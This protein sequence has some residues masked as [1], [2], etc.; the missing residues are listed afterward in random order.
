MKKKRL[1]SIFLS[2]CTL[3]GMVPS[4]VFAINDEGGSTTGSSSVAA[5]EEDSGDK[6]L[7]SLMNMITSSTP[8]GF[9]DDSTTPYGTKQDEIFTLLR[10]DE[11]FTFI[12]NGG[13]VTESSLMD[14]LAKTEFTKTKNGSNY[15]GSYISGSKSDTNGN[16][17]ALRFAQGVAFDPYGCGRRNYVAIVGYWHDAEQN[18]NGQDTGSVYLLI[19]NADANVLVCTHTLRAADVRLRAVMGQLTVV[20]SPNFFS[21]TAGDY[22]NDGKDTLVVYTGCVTSTSDTGLYEVTYQ[23]MSCTQKTIGTGTSSNNDSLLNSYYMSNTDSIMSS[24]ELRNQLTV[25]LATGDFN[26]DGA[27]DLLVLSGLNYPTSCYDACIPQL[28]IRVNSIGTYGR[29]SVWT[30]SI[31]GYSDSKYRSITSGS[32]SVGDVNEDGKS[33]VV[34]AGFYTEVGKLKDHSVKDHHIGYVILDKSTK[35]GTVSVKKLSNSNISGISQGD[36]LRENEYAIQQFAVECVAMRGVGQKEFVFLNGYLY[37]YNKSSGNLELLGSSYGSMM[38]NSNFNILHKAV[39]SYS[40]SDI[41]EVFIY[42]TSVG[43]VMATD[44]GEEAILL[45]VGYKTHTNANDKSKDQEGSYY[46]SKMIIYMNG[47]PD[48]AVCFDYF[49]EYDSTQRDGLTKSPTCVSG[50]GADGISCLLIAVDS[51]SDSVVAKYSQKAYTYTDPSP[52]A[53]LQA[54]PYFEEFDPGNSSTT[55]SYSESYS[56]TSGTTKEYTYDIG[57]TS[58]IETSAIKMSFDA[59]CSYELSEEFTKTMDTTYTTTF[60]ANDKNQVIIRQTVVYY[61]LYD[62]MTGVDD[63]GNP[64]WAEDSYVIAVPQ[65]PV[66][67]SLTVEQ[68][69]ALAGAYNAKVAELKASGDPDVDDH[70]LPTI[71][72]TQIE[73]YYLDNEGNPYNYAP[74]STS[75]KNGYDMYLEDGSS[76]WMRLS[77]AGGTLSQACTVSM[78]TEQSTTTSEG[79]YVNTSVMVGAEAFGIGA[80]GGISAGYSRMSGHTYSTA[81]M[82]EKETAGAVQNLTASDPTTY[83]FMWKLI[84][85]KDNSFLSGIP[86]IGYAVSKVSALLQPVSDLE[87]DY[88]YVD[89]T[90]TLTWTTP[91]FANGRGTID[92]FKVYQ[93]GEEIGWVD[94]AGAGQENS[95]VLDASTMD[96]K[97]TTFTVVSASLSNEKLNSMHSN[98][99]LCLLVLSATETLEKINQAIAALEE[100]I[101][102]LDVVTPEELAAAI[103]ELTEAYQAA[104]ALLK[105]YADALAEDLTALEAAM[106]SADQ[107]LQEAIDQVQENLDK[108]IEALNAAIA[109]GD[110][111]N[112][113]ALS[114][115]VAELTAAYQA[116]DALL[117]ADID[118][119]SDRLDALQTSMNEAYQALQEAIELVQVNVDT[120]VEE[121]RKAIAAGNQASADAL[122]QAVAELT[123]AYQAADALLQAENDSL[124]A[125]LDELKEAL[126][127]LTSQ[128]EAQNTKFEGEIENLTS[129]D[130]GQGETL[131]STRTIAMVGLCI[132]AVSLLGNLGLLGYELS[133]KKKIPVA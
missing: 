125:D 104:D 44:D 84:G 131:G 12:S 11:M 117:K 85:W 37:E 78:T 2:L 108:A 128:V 17:F 14:D 30:Y 38:T 75:Y 58:E 116:A 18:K 47:G 43:N 68:Y 69:N 52:V 72:Q 96:I 5:A 77:H 132:S 53:F 133:R 9:D 34:V 54:A 15:I 121:L 6:L 10:K 107:A 109:A 3:I 114:K 56:Y 22:N 62:V 130:Q 124:R 67:T 76:V 16:L 73:K 102:A 70:S 60:E 29:A 48:G 111:E 36:S 127:A 57:F 90:I 87:A 31:G 115:A 82:T 94:N 4:M 39:T 119:L 20:D 92:G 26:N 89:E 28:R 24:T 46:F 105:E 21:I 40:G 51:G 95:Y 7:E 66:I 126:S 98:E 112:A 100:K 86:C 61:Y 74:A 55:Y 8:E 88:S 35:E 97:Q 106:N 45:T 83:S 41:D 129:V 49:Q 1:L 81:Y 13:S 19:F 113:A 91:E 33:E 50:S 122:A 101:G 42:S 25:D 79:M 110:E 123:R 65:Y 23:D 27:D 93:D 71:S 99:A 59:G 103:A 120:L 118:S 32:V 64:A 80:Y 63:S